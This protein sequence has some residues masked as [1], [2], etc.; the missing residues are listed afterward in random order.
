MYVCMYTYIYIGFR[1]NPNPVF[2][3]QVAAAGQLCELARNG[4]LEKLRNTI[5]CGAEVT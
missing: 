2:F 1:V 3:G 4:M 5:R